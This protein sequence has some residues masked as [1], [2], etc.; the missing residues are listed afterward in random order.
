MKLCSITLSIK[1]IQ[2]NYTDK[3]LK[4]DIMD[5]IECYII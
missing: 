5:V 2:E 4:G 3:N 1:E